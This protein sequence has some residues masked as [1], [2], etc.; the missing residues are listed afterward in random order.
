MT[1]AR[2]PGGHGKVPSML[3]V[4]Y[5]EFYCLLL[6]LLLLLFRNGYN[7]VWF[8]IEAFLAYKLLSYGKFG[9]FKLD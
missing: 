3:L 5:I 8:C 1:K 4:F 6:L 9:L 7:F 2:K